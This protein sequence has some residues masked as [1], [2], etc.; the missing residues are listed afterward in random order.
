MKPTQLQFRT[1]LLLKDLSVTELISQ[2]TQ[3]P[4]KL[5]VIQ[6]HLY[7]WLSG[8]AKELKYKEV[9]SPILNDLAQFL[10]L[11]FNTVLTDPRIAGEQNRYHYT[12][13]QVIKTLELA[14]KNRNFF[15]ILNLCKQN[16][17]S[18]SFLKTATEKEKEYLVHL[19][20]MNIIRV[21]DKGFFSLVKDDPSSN[22]LRVRIEKQW[23]EE[24]SDKTHFTE[25][26]WVSPIYIEDIKYEIEVFSLKVKGKTKPSNC[27][28]GPDDALLYHY[29]TIFEH[30]SN[31]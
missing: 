6:N 18:Y 5:Q 17:T 3:E 13:G 28:P 4:R 30:T 15:R 23:L 1:Y 9:L 12:Y 27:P 8:H 26:V 14:K 11:T 7:K 24:L 19:L 20:R 31:L 10:N 29:S 21:S 25:G 16:K 22:N 2:F